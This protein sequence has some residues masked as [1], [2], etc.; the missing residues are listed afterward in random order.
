MNAADDIPQSERRR[1]MAE[2]RRG[3]TYQGHAI[4]SADED[5]GGRFAFSGGSTTVTG[6]NPMGW[7]KMPEG[8]FWAK[9][10]MPPEPLIDGTGEGNVLGYRIDDMTAPAEPTEQVQLVGFASALESRLANVP[11]AGAPLEFKRR[12]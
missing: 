5:R 9:N 8:N 11:N 2:E 7:P 10:E 4:N 6:S 1:I 3:R 12:L